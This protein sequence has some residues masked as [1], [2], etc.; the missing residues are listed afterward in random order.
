MNVPSS[1]PSAVLINGLIIRQ[2]HAID[3]TI[4]ELAPGGTKLCV[5]ADLSPGLPP[6]KVSKNADA[7]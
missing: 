6:P 2:I 5:N 3:A 4:V 1:N 7:S